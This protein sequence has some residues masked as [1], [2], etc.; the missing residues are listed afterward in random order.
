MILLQLPIPSETE[1]TSAKENDITPQRHISNEESF[2]ALQIVTVTEKLS[3][4]LDS[5]GTESSEI[6]ITEDYT[7][8]HKTVEATKK[9]GGTTAFNEEIY[10]TVNTEIET[11]TENL[12]N[13]ISTTSLNEATESLI[14][15]TSTATITSTIITFE[16]TEN[17]ECQRVTTQATTIDG[18]TMVSNE[19]TFTILQIVTEDYT[20]LHETVQATIKEG[21]TMAFNE[22]IYSTVN[23][24]IE[25]ETENLSN[26]ISTP[27]LV[28]FTRENHTTIMDKP[29]KH[30]F[31][32]KNNSVNDVSTVTTK[33]K[34]TSSIVTSSDEEV[35]AVDGSGNSYIDI[36]E[37]DDVEGSGGTIV[38]SEDEI[39]FPSYD[40]LTTTRI[41]HEHTTYNRPNYQLQTFKTVATL[42]TGIVIRFNDEQKKNKGSGN[43]DS[44]TTAHTLS[45]TLTSFFQ[46]IADDEDYYCCVWFLWTKPF[47]LYKLETGPSTSGEI[48]PEVCL[49]Y[50]KQMFI[51]RAMENMTM[52][53]YRSKK[54][55]G[56]CH[57][58]MGQE[59][60][61]VGIFNL[62]R[63]QNSIVT[64]YRVHS[65]AYLLAKSVKPVIAEL[66][67]NKKGISKGK[68]GSMHM[69]NTQLYG[70]AGIVGAQVPVGT[71]L[72]LAQMYKNNGGITIIGYGDGA[73]NQGQIFESYNIVKLWNFPS[74]FLC[75]NNKYSMGTSL[76]RGSA[77]E[78]AYTR[79]GYIPGLWTDGNDIFSVLEATKFIIG[80][81]TS[82]KGPLVVEASTY[83]F[84]GHS[85]SDPNISYRTR[86]EIQGER[87]RNDQVKLFREAIISLSVATDENL[88]TLE[89][90]L[91]KQVDSDIKAVM[92][93]EDLPAEE[94][95]YDIHT[96]NVETSIRGVNPWIRWQTGVTD[97]ASLP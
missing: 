40:E 30:Y 71:G 70:G 39:V 34:S 64:S 8:L 24:E 23:T 37:E 85:M 53:L 87:S 33:N 69:Y 44:D 41:N 97:P 72:S 49:E 29:G 88:K 27:Y 79:A 18:D 36:D 25:T 93:E 28:T 74:V 20:I 2:S 67:G 55:S 12:S 11:E 80:Y 61:A 21:G 90:S 59:A 26:K 94:L 84:T 47:K 68:G 6:F 83:R 22:E 4:I 31:Y 14:I 46:A 91:K 57:L 73:A 81:C 60:I 92:D 66:F 77:A 58:Y 65:W 48:S 5:I 1:I 9:E 16:P 32:N 62:L 96:K 56:F 86:D 19:E 54:I 17:K 95:S 82:G 63:P 76:K 3:S 89:D 50:Y 38:T 13:E 45:V 7:T 51:I 42:T 10:S 35:T 52:T 78:D 15:I 75:E 43:N